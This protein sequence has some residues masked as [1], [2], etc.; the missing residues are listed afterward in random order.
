MRS[1]REVQADA[2]LMMI[3]MI[4]R[5]PRAMA[6]RLLTTIMDRFNEQGDNS[7]FGLMNAVTSVA[8]DTRDPDLRWRL[9]ELGGGVPLADGC[10]TP[11]L[12][13]ARADLVMA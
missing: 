3:P 2:V 5:L 12:D 10:P 1:A 11:T 9:E 8:R 4:A 13:R 7:R 6:V